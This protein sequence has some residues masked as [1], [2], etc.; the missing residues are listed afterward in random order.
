MI[1]YELSLGLAVIG[2]VM[3]SR[4]LNLREIVEYQRGMWNVVWQPIGFLVY[5]TAAIAET[6]RVP[7]DLPEGETELVAGFHTEYSSLKFAMF[8]MA[9]YASMITVSCIATVFVFR[10][11]VG[12]GIWPGVVAG[13]SACFLVRRE[14][15]S[16]SFFYIW[17]RGTLPR[18]HMTN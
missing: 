11:L 10:G 12:S 8:F 17:M 16:I 5:F 14:G 18:F 3:I 9:E 7:F 6:N 4:T 2:V 13:Y 15:L 1:S